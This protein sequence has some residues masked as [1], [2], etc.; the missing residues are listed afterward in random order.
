M[1]DGIDITINLGPYITSL[2]S[3]YILTTDQGV[4]LLQRLPTNTDS[5]FSNG[6]FLCLNNAD[7]KK[8]KKVANQ[9]NMFYMYSS[10]YLKPELLAWEKGN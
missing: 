6:A 10:V 4:N 2:Y 8:V 9:S 5:H 7:N 3:G 1:F